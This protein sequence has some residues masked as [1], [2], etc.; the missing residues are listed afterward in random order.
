M[1]YCRP[2]SGTRRALN[3]HAARTQDS[4]WQHLFTCPL[5]PQLTSC[6]STQPPSPPHKSP[7]LARTRRASPPPAT[8]TPGPPPPIPERDA[9]EQNLRGGSRWEQL[10]VVVDHGFEGEE[11]VRDW[12]RGRHKH[13][14]EVQRGRHADV[15]ASTLPYSRHIALNLHA[16]ALQHA[17][18]PHT[19]LQHLVALLH[20]QHR[21]ALGPAYV[22]HEVTCEVP[23]V[24]EQGV[25]DA[26]RAAHLQA[27]ESKTA[28]L[29]L[30]HTRGLPPRKEWSNAG[31]AGAVQAATTHERGHT[32]T[33]RK[34]HT[35][36][37][38]RLQYERPV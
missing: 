4:H 1:I 24:V 3:T 12:R 23:V 17:I 16:R 7:L 34:T 36:L 26:A 9:R 32:Q 15:P 13:R 33:D 29:W 5:P 20:A 6:T 31:G 10:A 28:A 38:H 18:P 35:H 25:D 27:R 8:P 37:Q 22:V 19:Q 11:G 2:A 30:R 14:S 21:P